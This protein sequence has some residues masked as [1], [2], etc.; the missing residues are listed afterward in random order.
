MDNLLRIKIGPTPS[1]MYFGRPVEQLFSRLDALLLVLKRCKRESC[2]NAYSVLFPEGQASNLT[3]AMSSKYDA[4]FAGQPKVSF[5]ECIPGH[6]IA[7]EGP[8]DAYVYTEYI[9]PP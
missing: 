1:T 3:Q 6:I 9:Y 8:Q 4:F 5:A 2:R 7:L